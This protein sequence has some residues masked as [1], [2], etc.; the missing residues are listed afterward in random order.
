VRHTIQQGALLP[1]MKALA[2]WH[3]VQP[4]TPKAAQVLATANKLCGH[5]LTP[6]KLKLLLTR[7]DWMAYREEMALDE[8]ARARRRLEHRLDE[9]LDAHQWALREAKGAGDYKAVAAIADPVM[10]RAWPKRDVGS[11]TAQTIIVNLP[12]HTPAD[13]HVVEPLPDVE[14]IAV[15]T[16]AP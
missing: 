9:Y 11:Q 12:G 7:S 3:A 16:P 4:G 10:D 5:L 6:E 13:H 1:W 8:L 14:V 15:E 2:E